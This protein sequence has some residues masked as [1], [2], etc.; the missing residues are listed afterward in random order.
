MASVAATTSQIVPP[1]VTT[2]RAA[3]G[4]DTDHRVVTIEAPNTAV[5]VV[6]VTAVR[7]AVTEVRQ[8]VTAA[9]LSLV[10]AAVMAVRPVDPLVATAEVTNPVAALVVT[11]RREA[12]VSRR[13]AAGMASQ[14]AVT[15]RVTGRV[16]VPAIGRAAAVNRRAATVAVNRKVMAVV[17]A[18]GRVAVVSQLAATVAVMVKPAATAEDRV[19]DPVVVPATGQAAVVN[20]AVATD[21]VMSRHEAVANTVSQ[22]AATPEATGQVLPA[23]AIGP[24]PAAVV[25]T[26]PAPADEVDGPAVLPAIEI[27]RVTTE[28]TGPAATNATTT[29]HRNVTTTQ[30]AS[31]PRRVTTNA[32]DVARA[33]DAPQVADAAATTT[34][35]VAT[36]K[37][38]DRDGAA[39][40]AASRASGTSTVAKKA[41]ANNALGLIERLTRW[42][43]GLVTKTPNGDVVKMRIADV[44]QRAIV[45]PTNASRKT[46][47]N[48]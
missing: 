6:G 42:R 5:Q 38:K 47:T 18:T 43:R 26:G 1:G 22:A 40:M 15:D 27:V 36:A 19:T 31:V 20:Q 10:A 17:R 16:A 44:V 33:A 23:E 12:T 24:P 45:V 21:V 28:V 30:Q 11:D 29:N 2:S 25:A 8:V 46:S 39:V 37:A 9:A 34:I 7:P 3:P 4:A 14:A 41:G 48:G 32:A 13:V 35:A